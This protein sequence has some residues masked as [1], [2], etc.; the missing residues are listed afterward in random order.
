MPSILI[1]EGSQSVARLF[2][3]ILQRSDWEIDTTSEMAQAVD[4]LQSDRP[5]DA[6]LVSFKISGGDGLSLV[7]LIRTLP[8]RIETPVL[9][10]TGTPGVEYDAIAAGA[11]EVLRKPIDMHALVAAVAK[12]IEPAAEGAC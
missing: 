7:K 1:V 2:A 10:V 12:H 3:T 6:V 9:M 5:I 11:N 8:H 4:T